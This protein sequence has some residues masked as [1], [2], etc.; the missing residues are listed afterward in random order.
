[1]LGSSPLSDRGSP[2][3][4]RS[5]LPWWAR[6]AALL[7]LVVAGCGGPSTTLT[8]TVT[9][10]GRPAPAG[11]LLEFSPTAAGTSAYTAT[12]AQGRA[13]GR[14][15]ACLTFRQKGIE[16]G[17]HRVRLMPG[18]A[19]VSV[20]R[21]SGAPSP[22]APPLRPLTAPPGRAGGFPRAYYAEIERIMIQPGRNHHDLSLSTEPPS[23]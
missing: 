9:V 2:P 19:A 6:L 11:L 18:S 5:G 12:D 23:R 13:Q 7:T 14:Y 22:A 8:G 16:P 21:K 10:D 3:R 1:M 17:E 4:S 20:A 15:E